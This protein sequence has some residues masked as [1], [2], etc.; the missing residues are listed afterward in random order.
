MDEELEVKSKIWNLPLE[1]FLYETYIKPQ[2]IAL[3]D[4][5]EIDEVAQIPLIGGLYL[6]KPNQRP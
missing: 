5:V 4:W 2:K 3:V 1:G 6:V